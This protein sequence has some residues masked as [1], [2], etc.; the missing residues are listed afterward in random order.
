MNRQ[1]RHN[2]QEIELDAS[3]EL[4]LNGVSIFD[5]SD[6]KRL[7][8]R[9]SISNLLPIEQVMKGSFDLLAKM[10]LDIYNVVQF[11]HSHYTVVYVVSKSWLEKLL[12]SYNDL[13]SQNLD[14]QEVVNE[15]S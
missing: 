3:Y 14:S 4:M 7:C 13:I 15:E 2:I 10:N 1:I 5:I 6:P 9:C 11:D 12:A 8:Y